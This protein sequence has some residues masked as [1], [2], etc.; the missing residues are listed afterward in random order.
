MIEVYAAVDILGGRCVRL[1]RGDTSDPTDYGDPVEMAERWVEEGCDWL[2]VV[3]LDGAVRGAPANMSKVAAIIAT[4]A[5]PV[6]LGG[7]LRDAR[8]AD[9]ALQAGCERVVI[10]SAA[11][12]EPDWVVELARRRPGRIALALDLVEGEVAIKGWT[13]RSGLGLE[14]VVRKLDDAPF[15]AL[16]VT[17][18]ASDGVMQGMRREFVEGVLDAIDRPVIVSGGLSSVDDAASLASLASDHP[19]GRNLRGIIVGRALYEGAVTIAELKSALR[20]S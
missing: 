19:R 14:E 6:Q 18:I 7:G 15:A 10:G 13:E 5:A 4:A 8:T 12:E 2:H 9:A 1:R 11:L 20:R 16:I 17:D 3:D